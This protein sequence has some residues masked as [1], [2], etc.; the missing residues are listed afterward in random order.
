MKRP[1]AILVSVPALALAIPAHA[2]EE[3]VKLQD[4]AGVQVVRNNCVACHS[5]DYS[6]LNSPFLDQKGWEA[7]VTKMVKAF[8][9]PIKPED[10]GPI[11]EYLARHYGK[12]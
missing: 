4:G 12:K 6:P 5:L 10:Q 3:K 1:I 8:G 9:A 11:A 7:V 2:G